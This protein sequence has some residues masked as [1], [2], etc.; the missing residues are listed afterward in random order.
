MLTDF[1]LSVIDIPNTFSTSHF[2]QESGLRPLSDRLEGLSRDLVDVELSQKIGGGG[3]R[4]GEV[5]WQVALSLPEPRK[6]CPWHPRKVSELVEPLHTAALQ[7]F[8]VGSKFASFNFDISMLAKS[9]W[10]EGGNGKK[11]YEA[12]LLKSGNRSPSFVDGG[13]FV[14]PFPWSRRTKLR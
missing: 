1:A 5:F 11:R 3:E 13:C 7:R 9:K 10:R 2:A 14:R 4:G 12:H 8:H 6:T